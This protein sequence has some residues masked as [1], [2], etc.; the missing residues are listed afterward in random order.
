VYLSFE[1]L[2][3]V[4]SVVVEQGKVEDLL[5]ARWVAVLM[6]LL[7]VITDIQNHALVLSYCIDVI[8]FED[9]NKLAHANLILCILAQIFQSVVL[10]YTGYA[11][12]MSEGNILNILMHFA[13]VL[14]LMRYDN[15]VGS[16]FLGQLTSYDGMMTLKLTGIRNIHHISEP[17][18]VVFEVYSKII[19]NCFFTIMLGSMIFSYNYGKSR[20][21]LM[22]KWRYMV[23]LVFSSILIA[24]VLSFFIFLVH[25]SNARK[26]KHMFGTVKFRARINREKKYF[27]VNKTGE[28]A[29]V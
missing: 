1:L 2:F 9:V 3:Y 14:G 8:I 5:F 20:I 28:S 17:F 26:G 13:G 19:S 6:I 18:K 22:E 29:F 24:L 16:W 11:T 15:I 27:D 4:T 21:I 23:A 25:C 7:M 12:M 10:G